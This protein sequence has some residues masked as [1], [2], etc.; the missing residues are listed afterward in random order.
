[1][2]D[3]DWR[4]GPFGTEPFVELNL[5]EP[6]LCDGGDFASD[7]KKRKFTKNK[8]LEPATL[9]SDEDGQ[10]QGEVQGEAAS[11]PR[12]PPKAPKSEKVPKVLKVPKAPKTLKEPKDRK[13]RKAPSEKP[14]L[15][16]TLRAAP[17]T[18]DLQERY[19]PG[20]PMQ[21]SHKFSIV[22]GLEQQSPEQH[23]Y[24]YSVKGDF[25]LFQ[26]GSVRTLCGR[27]KAALTRDNEFQPSE[28]WAWTITSHLSDE[29]CTLVENEM[30]NRATMGLEWCGFIQT[31]KRAFV[32]LAHTEYGFY[33]FMANAANPARLILSYKKREPIRIQ[34]L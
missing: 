13:Q 26:K 30:L 5:L 11:W 1:M 12:R 8:H 2:F 15:G 23:F 34:M 22:I 4:F 24:A 21:G 20:Q 14:N 18:A 31:E 10:V 6:W 3:D 25:A 29:P 19:V 17:G 28:A 7:G 16:F 27:Y 9:D 32:F 33:C